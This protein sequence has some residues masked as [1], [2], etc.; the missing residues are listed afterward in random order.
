MN[1]EISPFA[2]FLDF[3][4][5]GW[6]CSK[7]IRSHS[8]AMDNGDTQQDDIEVAQKTIRT[9]SWKAYAENPDDSLIES[10][11]VAEENTKLETEPGT[12]LREQWMQLFDPASRKALKSVT[13]PQPLNDMPS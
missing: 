7:K 11:V 9:F 13:F 6:L 5:L 1:L 8:E 3:R 12:T 2:A 10:L 4:F